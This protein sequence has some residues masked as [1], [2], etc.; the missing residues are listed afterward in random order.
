MTIK[1]N[2]IFEKNENDKKKI[3]LDTGRVIISSLSSQYNFAYALFLAEKFFEKEISSIEELPPDCKLIRRTK[4][5]N[6][7]I[8]EIREIRNFVSYKSISKNGKLVI[9]DNAELLSTEAQ[10][11][12][13]KSLEEPGEKTAFILC[14][15]NNFGLLPTIKSRAFT[16]KLNIPNKKECMSIL[17][18]EY[19]NET[20]YAL[21]N[22][23]ITDTTE[24]FFIK[25]NN[26]DAQMI[27]SADYRAFF[28]EDFKAWISDVLEYKV[29]INH[30]IIYSAM[31]NLISELIEKITDSKVFETLSLL[32]EFE[33]W[34]NRMSSYCAKE[35]DIQKT[36]V[37]AIIREKIYNHIMLSLSSRL[38]EKM[39]KNGNSSIIKVL[40]LIE[41]WFISKNIRFIPYFE[42]IL[43]QAS[44]GERV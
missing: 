23:F 25:D 9:I 13:L 27:L 33:D 32:Y 30:A 10:N 26:I 19:G 1:I 38:K 11:A 39:I 12:L 15:T 4:E 28:E 5:N 40:E 41:T 16:A 37:N 36:A 44:N 17:S 7:S 24:L 21:L 29:G 35:I 18:E 20:A 14:T 2:A 43:I 8:D 31:Q 22:C 3:F 34:I 6:I 42:N